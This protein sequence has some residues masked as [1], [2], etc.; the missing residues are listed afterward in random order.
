MEQKKVGI[1]PYLSEQAI[2]ALIHKQG[3]QTNLLVNLMLIN[4]HVAKTYWL[5]D[6]LRLV[7]PPL[8]EKQLEQIQS[9]DQVFS[10]MEI[11][12]MQLYNL[13]NQLDNLY[14][15]IE[16]FYAHDTLIIAKDSLIRIL[17]QD[18]RLNAKYNLVNRYLSRNDTTKSNLLLQSIQQ[19]YTL[20]STM[21]NEYRNFKQL[22]SIEL[23]LKKKGKNFSDLSQPQQEI[24]IN[25][26]K[27]PSQ[28]LTEMNDLNAL[29][30][31]KEIA[32]PIGKMGLQR[33][34]SLIPEYKEPILDPVENIEKNKENSDSVNNEELFMEGMMDQVLMNENS[35]ILYPNPAFEKVTV[36][37][38]VPIDGTS[39][40][41]EITNCT[42]ILVEK[43]DLN[44]KD[45][46][47]NISTNSL[48]KGLYFV[49]LVCNNKKTNVIKLVIQ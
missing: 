37:Y 18:P 13:I 47:L 45:N 40:T 35:L 26:I 27:H 12:R 14:N 29:R 32:P 5:M 30:Q 39:A 28:S 36:F 17:E 8:S 20:D 1:K 2:L 11:E 6:A 22:Y 44:V 46:V 4:T 23:E 49:S 43:Y 15:G 24:L 10:E 34:K 7:Q 41:L 42:G 9:K 48:K 3:F 38:N 21:L 16:S 25:T 33:N 31:V 19:L